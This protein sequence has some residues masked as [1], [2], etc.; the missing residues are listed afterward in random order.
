MNFVQKTSHA[1]R[2]IPP[3]LLLLTLLCAPLACGP[4]ASSETDMSRPLD[5]SRDPGTDLSSST[6][7]DGSS[8]GTPDL[9]VGEDASQ[10][11][12]ELGACATPLGFSLARGHAIP[13]SRYTIPV[14][15]GAGPYAFS[16][17]QNNSEAT[18]DGARGDYIAGRRTNTTDIVQVEDTSCA[19]RATFEIDVLEPFVAR[20]AEVELL[21]GGTFTYV[22]SGGSGHFTFTIDRNETGGTI[23]EGGVYHAGPTPGRD[24]IFITDERTGQLFEAFVYV[25]ANARFRAASEVIVMPLGQ[26]HELRTVGGSGSFSTQIAGDAVTLDDITLSAMQT[27]FASLILSDDFLDAETILEVQVVAPLAFEEL[28]AGELFNKTV[29]EAAHDLDGDGIEDL[30]FALP[31]SDLAGWRSGSVF[32]YKGHA[33]GFDQDPI[34]VFTGAQSDDF[35]GYDAEIAD[36]DGDGRLDLLVGARLADGAATNSGKVYFFKG[37]QGGFFESEASME[38][39]GQQVS[40]EFGWDVEVCDFDGDGRLDLAVGAPLAEDL[41][42]SPVASSQGAVHIYLNTDAQGPS[43]SPDLSLW[44]MA[45]V[46]D[47]WTHERSLSM[48][49]NLAS[50]DLD[51]DGLCDLAVGLHT[52]DLPSQNDVGA[53]FL[54][55]GTP[56]GLAALPNKAILM[57][58]PDARNANFGWRLDAGPATDDDHDDLLVGAYAFYE[59]GQSRGAAFLYSEQAPLSDT[60]AASYTSASEARWSRVGPDNSSR[61]GWDVSIEA[62]SASTGYALHVS[63]YNAVRSG[64]GRPG[65]VFVY[66]DVI[67]APD[68]ASS[69]FGI[70]SGDFFGQGSSTTQDRDGDGVRDVVAFAAR[71]SSDGLDLGKLYLV[72]SNGPTLPNSEDPDPSSY[73]GYAFPDVPSGSF[74]GVSG[75]FVGDLDG[76]GRPEL[77]VGASGYETSL[78]SAVN[79]GAVLLYAST[80]GGHETSP[81]QVLNGFPTNSSSDDFGLELSSAGDFNGDGLLDLAVLAPRDDR[82]SNYNSASAWAPN[83][84]APE[85][86]S[87]A[88]ALYIFLGTPNGLVEPSPAFILHGPQAA[89][90]ITSLA[91]GEYDINADGFDDLILGSQMW[92]QGGTNT[93]GI[94]IVLGRPDQPRSPDTI[95]PICEPDLLLFGGVANDQVGFSVGFLGDLNGDGCAEFAAAARASDLGGIND[96]GHVRI[97]QSTDCTLDGLVF[98]AVAPELASALVGWSMAAG[99][100]DVTGDAVPDLAVSANAYTTRGESAGAAWLLDG[101][102]LMSLP[103]LPISRHD[104]LTDDDIHPFYP[105]TQSSPYLIT[106]NRSGDEFGHDIAL[107]PS[108]AEGTPGALFIGARRAPLAGTPASGGGYLYRYQRPQDGS[109]PGFEAEPYLIFSGESEHQDGLLGESVAAIPFDDQVHLMIGGSRS[110]LRGQEQGVAFTFT[111]E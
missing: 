62:S 27:G 64:V 45:L 15:G 6:P 29:I 21:P 57:D 20:P 10:D 82:P 23:E 34:Q 58:I 92:D 63:D 102:Y 70:L 32:V 68:A 54:Y 69:L 80:A 12:G 35:F 24:A 77:A 100:V 11:L 67:D 65:A 98:T 94:G 71:D 73:Q 108:F 56:D 106:G 9:T 18:L 79:P 99:G 3:A 75:A 38:W 78:A 76:D 26:T 53:V 37:T 36:L 47:T 83:S 19:Q 107:V 55:K 95:T 51:G 39:S 2:A 13:F 33:T 87:D 93:G 14:T 60:P 104:T 59:A 4:D 89:Q 109:A 72:P 90:R 48:G 8:D 7:D 105:P 84:C 16:F 43:S 31:E 85:N 66:E 17:V 46:G 5:M 22:V 50:G 88:G 49:R 86:R 28:H 74:V 97:Y 101:A 111:L 42:Q 61:F 110:W 41:T 44:G 1:S 91:G 103:T 52:F 30:V 25:S 96:Q 40:D 81:T